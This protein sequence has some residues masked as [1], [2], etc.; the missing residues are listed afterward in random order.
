MTTIVLLALLS[1]QVPTARVDSLITAE[2][3]T[4][5]IPGVAIAVVDDGNVVMKK[6]YGTANLET[7]TPMRT[8]AV[9]ELAS[10]T[11]QFT[12]AAIMLLV[13]DGKVKLDEPIASYIDNTPAAWREI[14]V[15]HLLTHTGGLQIS[16]VPRPATMNIPTQSAFDFVTKQP[17]QFPAGTNGWYSDA[18]YFLLGLIIE[19]ASAQTYREFM[20]DRVFD[21]LQMTNT[22]LTDRFRVIKGRV[23]TYSIAPGRGELINWRRDWDY[24]VPSF[25]GIWSTLD[26]LVKWDLALRNATLLDLA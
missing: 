20:Q 25:F 17:A 18:G 23:A 16:A 1:T 9:F 21:P 6:A 24:E 26:D 10:I 15:R 5:R 2:M 14:T 12:A 22:S 8:D 11:K 4:R 3:K 7:E 19:K 13:R